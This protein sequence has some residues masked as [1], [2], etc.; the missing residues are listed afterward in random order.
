MRFVFTRCDTLPKLAWCAHMW[1]GGGVARV[2]HGPWV[3]TR[4]EWFIEGGWT[5]PFEKGQLD[6]ALFLVGSGGVVRTGRAVFCTQTEMIEPA[7]RRAIAAN[8]TDAARSTNA[9]NS[10]G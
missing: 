10:H 9:S 1:R 7:L 3:E 5:G 4:D 2:Y 8:A 6:N